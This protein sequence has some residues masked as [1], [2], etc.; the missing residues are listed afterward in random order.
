M[1]NRAETLVVF[2]AEGETA[3]EDEVDEEDMEEREED[4]ACTHFKYIRSLLHSV[5]LVKD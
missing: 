1:L 3:V 5:F 4:E 2:V